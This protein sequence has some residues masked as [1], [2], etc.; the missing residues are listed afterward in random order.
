[1]LEPSSLP[2]VLLA[3]R[4]FEN[5]IE[6]YLPEDFSGKIEFLD[7]GLHENPRNLKKTL[8]ERLNGL[9]ESSLVVLGYG[10]CGNGLHGLQSG[11]HYLLAPRTDDC[12]AIFFGSYATYREQFDASPG[13]YYLT[14]G[15]FESGSNP[16]DEYLKYV[17]RYGE[18]QADWLVDQLYQNYKRL[19]FIAHRQADLDQYREKA[20]Q[21]AKFCQR[22]GMK[23]EEILG[24]ELYVRNLIQS[25][26]EPA[27]LSN[28]FILIPPGGV[29]EQGQY[30]RQTS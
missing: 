10:L 23:Y 8:Q 15:W 3:C 28:E 14:K 11:K 1:M 22:W 24:S 6:K 29:L 20:L 18:S 19:V 21:V 4:V 17:E 27:S 7:F 25:A 12:I 5:L 30:I 9:D 13:T 16:L 2:F 26:L